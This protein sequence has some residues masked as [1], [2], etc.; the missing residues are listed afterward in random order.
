M[1]GQSAIAADYRAPARTLT[2]VL[3]L[4]PWLDGSDRA[5]VARQLD[6]ICREIGFFYLRGHGLPQAR[7]DEVLAAAAQ[8]FALPDAD[9]RALTVDRARRGYE[10]FGLQALDA[11]APADLKESLL[12]GLGQD[13]EHPCVRRGLANYGANRWPAA[14]GMA[15]FRQV[16]EAWFADLMGLGHTLMAVFATVAGLPEDHFAPLLVDPMVTLRLIHYPPQPG[17]VVNRQLGCGEHTDWGAFTLLL[18][19]ATG[20]LE[21]QAADG[22]WLYADPV[23]GTL[24]VNIGD[25]MPVW[26]NGAYQSNRHRVRNRH[27]ERHRHSAAFFIDPFYDAEVACLDAFRVAGEPPRFP[28]RTVGEHIDAM[29]ARSYGQ[30]THSEES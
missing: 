17:P 9:K 4:A 6:R 5:G 28:P 26:T 16:C 24:V 15:H 29:Y 1:S 2:P 22:E 18:Q 23:P 13:E 12:I 3:D 7:M 19:D 14:P 11:T 10:P 30:A 25:M 21:I 20:G 8:F 27:P